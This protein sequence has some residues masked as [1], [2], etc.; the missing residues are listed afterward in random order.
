MRIVRVPTTE[1]DYRDWD[2]RAK[3]RNGRRRAEANAIK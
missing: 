1:L 2:I 3:K